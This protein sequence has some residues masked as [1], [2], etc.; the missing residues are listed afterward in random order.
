[1]VLYDTEA[2]LNDA[3]YQDRERPDGEGVRGF[4]MADKD[5]DVCYI[6]IKAA[7]IWDDRE[8]MAIIGHE[9]YHCALAKHP[10]ATYA[11]E[12]EME[13]KVE[14]T[15]EETAVA[16]KDIILTKLEDMPVDAQELVDETQVM[17]LD[18]LAWECSDDNPHKE[19]FNLDCAKVSN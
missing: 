9:L 3:Y 7:A 11:P 2:E 4:A 1:L 14:P 13:A 18:L 5:E 15:E 8:N 12:L 19:T 17:M 10:T 6:H 16:T